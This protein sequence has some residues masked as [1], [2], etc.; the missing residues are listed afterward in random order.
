MARH[1]AFGLQAREVQ[2][3][4]VNVGPLCSLRRSYNRIVFF[5]HNS[6]QKLEIK[7]DHTT[8]NPYK[9]SP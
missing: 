3:T 4:V 7:Q 1:R 5:I 6:A 9:I 2:Y 8:D